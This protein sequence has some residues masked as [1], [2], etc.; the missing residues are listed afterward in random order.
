MKI[1]EVL[2]VGAGPVGMTLACILAQNGI[3]V[4]IVDKRSSTSSI[5]R[6]INICSPVLTIFEKLGLDVTVLKDALKLNEMKVFWNKKPLLNINY[7]YFKA[8]HPYFAHLEQS[9]IERHLEKRLLDLGVQVQ[10]LTSVNKIKQNGHCVDVGFSENSVSKCNEESFAYVI[11]CDGGNSTIRNLVS[12]PMEETNYPSHFV[13]IDAEV[14]HQYKNGLNSLQYYAS[15]AGYLIVAPTPNNKC[16]LIVSFKGQKSEEKSIYELTEHFQEIINER[17]AGHIKIKKT[18]W[19]TSG[20]FFHKIASTAQVGRVFIAGDALHQFSPIGGTNMNVGIQDAYSLGKKLE[21][22]ISGQ[23]DENYLL[24]YSVERIN[25]AKKYI[26]ITSKLTALLTK[27]SMVDQ[28]EI[29]KYLPVMKNR[30][31][32]K[33]TLPEMFSG[34]YFIN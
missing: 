2:I 21:A 10:R 8:V 7:K 29:N 33:Y 1:S 26:D 28:E 9:K 12:I 31:F 17:G 19:S 6:A 16:R 34:E 22:V 32:I 13:L 3:R 14:E 24:A 5:P 18:I 20:N 30:N 4:K 15:E 27:S 11:G 25:V 23:Q